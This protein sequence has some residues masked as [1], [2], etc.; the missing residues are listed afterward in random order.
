LVAA[1]GVACQFACEVPCAGGDGFGGIDLRA[2][3]GCVVGVLA[4]EA[5]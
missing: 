5:F 3:P 2:E 4:C 1:D